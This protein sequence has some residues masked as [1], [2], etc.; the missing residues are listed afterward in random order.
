MTGAA[1]ARIRSLVRKG[2]RKV[3]YDIVPF[4]AGTAQFQRRSLLTCQQVIDVGANV[5]Q[6]AE[7][8]R[9]LGFQGP[10]LSFEPSGNA[11]ST[12][13]SKAAADDLWEVRNLAIGE[14]RG[15][16]TLLISEN[17]VSSSLLKVAPLHLDAAPESRLSSTE[18][19]KVS[20]L[21]DELADDAQGLYLKLDIQGFELAA[22][23]GAV[24][25]LSS[26]D[27]VQVEV[28]FAPLYENQ[29]SWLD[30]SRFLEDHGFA[31]V[32]VD[33]G[34]EH[35]VTTQMLQADLFFKRQTT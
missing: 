9:D 27:I 32:W 15:L 34:Y 10:I 7:R 31:V 21:D 19:V 25:A 5:G 12:L 20:T 29:G 26:A 14:K 17:S 16:A 4:S 3:G 2:V 35:R 28:S 30:V 6:F 24:N 33:P 8:V 18:T 23:R 11:Y 22:L 13:E 1:K